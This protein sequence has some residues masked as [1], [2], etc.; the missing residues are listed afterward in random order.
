MKLTFLSGIAVLCAA[1]ASAQTPTQSQPGAQ[2]TTPSGA[3][4]T[5]TLT[6]CVGSLSGSPGGVMSDLGDLYQQV[7]L[8][9]NR[10][11]RNFK[12]VGP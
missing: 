12:R 8:D 6:G 5:T 10:N 2:P 7:I 9:H 4:Q 3:A 1:A 11:P